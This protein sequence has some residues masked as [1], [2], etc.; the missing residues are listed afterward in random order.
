MKINDHPTVRAVR[1]RNAE[2]YES[3]APTADEVVRL[4]LDA[5]ADDA[6][7]VSLDRPELDDQRADILRHAPWVRSLLSFVCKMNREPVRSPARS[8]S[9]LEF[10]HTGDRRQRGRPA[11]WCSGCSRS[12]GVPRR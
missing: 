6:G 9:N 1:S 3:T 5:G 7:I 2:D 4:C 8:M 12:A 10:H 11:G